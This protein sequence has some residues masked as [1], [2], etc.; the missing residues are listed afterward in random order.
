MKPVLLGLQQ[1]ILVNCHIKFLLVWILPL[2]ITLNALVL[3]KS[4]EICAHIGSF[5]QF[6]HT[7]KGI[8]EREKQSNS[9]HKT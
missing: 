4:E 1:V 6:Y 5:H 8:S 7:Q 3:T 9:V 2:Y